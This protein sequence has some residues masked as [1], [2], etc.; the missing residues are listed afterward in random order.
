M[1]FLRDI[2]PRELARLSVSILQVEQL[3]AGFLDID[4]NLLAEES[5]VILSLNSSR[6]AKSKSRLMSSS[7]FIG[8]KMLPISSN[9]SSSL[10][11]RDVP[12]MIGER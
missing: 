8:S 11:S 6:L 2:L 5:N 3:A 1:G 7:S 10:L 9:K 4:S 12:P